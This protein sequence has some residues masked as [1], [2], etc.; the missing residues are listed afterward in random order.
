MR[1]QPFPTEKP[2]DVEFV[3]IGF[4]SIERI[5]GAVLLH[6]AASLLA[7]RA[8]EG[9]IGLAKRVRLALVDGPVGVPFSKLTNVLIDLV[10][11]DWR[12]VAKR[13]VDDF[14]RH[15][16]PDRGH[17]FVFEAIALS[18]VPLSQYAEKF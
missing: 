9:L 6:S 11:V 17:P 12:A 2:F 8:P 5:S 14:L 10:V 16:V 1:T 15:A 7:M 4:Q 18:R 13:I 3:E